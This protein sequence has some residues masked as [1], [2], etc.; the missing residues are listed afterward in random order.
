MTKRALA[1]GLLIGTFAAG[2][3][4]SVDDIH[5]S[6]PAAQTESPPPPATGGSSTHETNTI[7]N[8]TGGA[9][10]GAAGAASGGQGGEAG[11]AGSPGTGGNGGEPVINEPNL[12]ASYT[13]DDVTGIQDDS[14][15]GNHGTTDGAGV[16]LGI[17]GKTGKAISFSGL[18]GHVTIPASTELDFTSAAT[19]E[20]WVRLN[21]VT[22]GTILS[23]GMGAGDN[24]VFVKT[25]QGNLQVTFARAGLGA[26]QLV[27]NANVIGSSWA[28]VAIVND[29]STLSLYIDG[30]LEKTEVG[31]YLG[32][33]AKELRI[34]KSAASD[35]ALN[36]MLDDVKW[37]TI[38]RTPAD[39][40]SDAGGSWNVGDGNGSCVLSP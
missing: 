29:G 15:H 10:G 27:S 8:G 22:A 12:A 6:P 34:G 31:G 7:G 17:Q 19:I 36:G 40:C 3:A 1:L 21:S 4:M 26:T 16:S 25:A 32:S 18:D 23:R 38:V 37:W 33:I 20:F 39:I 2:C 30:Q 9:T 13:F 11:Q 14:G 35:T 5:G 24:S 28:H